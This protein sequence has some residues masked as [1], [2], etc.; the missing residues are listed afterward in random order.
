MKWLCCL[1]LVPYFIGCSESLETEPGPL[2]LRLATT[3]STRDSGLLD[4]L[5]PLFKQQTGI[6]VKVIAVGTGQA[7]E[8]GRRGD[9]DVLL[10]HAPD[11]EKQFIAEGHAEQRHEIMYNDFVLLGPADDPADLKNL[12]SVV[13]AFARIA[14]RNAPFVSRGDNSGT[15]QKE[16]AIWALSKVTDRGAGYLESGSGMATVLRMANQKRA[17]T[18]SDRATFLAQQSK[19]EALAVLCEGDPLLLNQ[20]AV[21]VVNSK[22]LTPAQREAADRFI[23]FLQSDV[24]Q[25][26]I[27]EFGKELYGQSLFFPGKVPVGLDSSD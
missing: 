21:M 20:Y 7:L 19:N 25:R 3:T 11:A 6:E 9:A 1:L 24:I 2:S 23:E 26:M 17:Y 14:E 18:L 8:L 13:E 27:S 22:S 10:T 12:E 4:V 16:L 15:Q 5:V